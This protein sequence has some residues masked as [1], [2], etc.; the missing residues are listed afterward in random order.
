VEVLRYDYRGIGESEGTFE[1]MS[2]SQWNEDVSLLA[3][4]LKDQSPDAPLVLHGLE[5]GAILAGRA[6]HDGIGE[7]LLLWSPP[8]NANVALRS[9]LLRWVGLDQIFK[10][11]TGRK[12]A[13]A[14]I[15]ELEQGAFI[16]V[17]GYQ[18]SWKLWQDSIAFGLP[19]TFADEGT[20]CSEYKRPV[21]IVKLGK[22]A[23]PLV[24]GGV[25]GYDE[26]KDLNWLFVEN[27]GWIADNLHKP[28]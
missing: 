17:E 4:W 13:S 8:A 2:F 23:V 7:A 20:A 6:F 25:L 27:W 1:E 10:Y 22:E 12:P 9:M 21:R 26:T 24:K 18:W 14:Y 3:R 19:S 5:I 28:L 16:E 11:G 15:R